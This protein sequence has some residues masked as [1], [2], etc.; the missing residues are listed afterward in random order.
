MKID[1]FL[2]Q[3]RPKS[4]L[5]AIGKSSFRS[6]ALLKF[7][8]EDQ[9]WGYADCHPWPELGDLPLNEQLNQLR[10]ERW[11][12][13]TQRSWE[14]AKVDAQ[15]RAEKVSLFKDARI[16]PSHALI[17]DIHQLQP[18]G[19]EKLAHQGFKCLKIK[20]G[21]QL[22]DEQNRLKE[23]HPILRR[24]HL[25]VRLDFNQVLSAQS[26]NSYLREQSDLLDLID[27]IEDPMPYVPEEWGKV[28][29]KWGIRLALD[30][31]PPGQKI[32]RGTF[33][34]SI[35]KPALQD[36]LVWVQKALELGTSL[37]VTTYLDH[38]LGQFCAAWVS[39]QVLTHTQVPLE[40]CGLLSQVAYEYSEP[41]SFIQSEGPKL[42]P[43]KGLGMGMDEYLDH[44]DWT[45]L[46][47]VACR[48]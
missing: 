32:E 46:E 7:Y 11:T 28:E 26:L 40:T 2:Y 8:F 3:L 43:P 5:N 6:G 24:H 21:F 19:I 10:H 29:R 37:V 42:L 25:K 15:A 20:S 48:M 17:L 1:A 30:H 45:P 12:P 14:F 36:P 16:A 31:H 22:K 35:L 41:F 47:N 9:K 23:L 34:V 44:L 33:S 4:Q 18:E 27:F 38:P 13:I 39:S